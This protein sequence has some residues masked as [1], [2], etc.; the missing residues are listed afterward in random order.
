MHAAAPGTGRLPS[1]KSICGSMINNNRRISFYVFRKKNVVPLTISTC[2]IIH[3]GIFISFKKLC[4]AAIRFFDI[5][6]DNKRREERQ[7]KNEVLSLVITDAIQFRC[8][9]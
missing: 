2:G 5:V 9:V 1:I 7:T 8:R 3:Y 4:R 6:K